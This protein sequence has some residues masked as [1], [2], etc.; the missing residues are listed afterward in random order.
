MIIWI[1]TNLGKHHKVL[2]GTLLGI[3]IVSFV[4]FGTWSRAGKGAG[5]STYLGVDFS[6]SRDCA[7][8]RDLALL[9][10][11]GREGR[12]SADALRMLVF[13]VHLANVVQ[14]PAPT[15]EQL[16]TY[17]DSKQSLDTSGGNFRIVST[18]ERVPALL[19]LLQE[20]A[21]GSREEATRR[22]ENALAESW[23]ISRVNEL[24][25]GPGFAVPY[26]AALLWRGQNT[27]WTLE[28]ASFDG[29]QFNPAIEVPEEALKIYFEN[30][31]EDFRIPHFVRAS[32]AIFKPTP[33]DAEST[34]VE[35]TDG[36]LRKHLYDNAQTI[37]GLDLSKLDEQIK[38]RR[39]EFAQSWRDLQINERLAG[40]IS[41]LLNEQFPFDEVR[42]SEERVAKFLKDE[43]ATSGT[44]PAFNENNIPEN[45]PL[46]S[47][48]LQHALKL[49]K[50][51]WRSDVYVL[52]KGEG[53]VVFF[54][55]EVQPARI[56][57]LDEVREKV[58][59]AW[60][61]QERE[62]L[63]SERATTLERQLRTA[64]ASGKKFTD[65][66]KELGLTTKHFPAFKPAAA[67]EELLLI[68][69]DIWHELSLTQT[70]HITRYF[71]KGTE[72]TYILVEA[73][74]EPL[75]DLKAP[76]ILSLAEQGA[77]R[78]ANRSLSGA[79]VE[80]ISWSAGK[81]Q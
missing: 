74:K 31:K 38:T 56:P 62:R 42:A 77:R 18:R 61:A 28:T 39:A 36:E 24:L 25:T 17:L 30:Q 54:L 14:I 55:Q 53:A 41:S 22:L 80:L 71:R 45:L 63:L 73:R 67:P 59:A 34:P 3:T 69:P 26:E 27:E 44:L 68:G 21:S 47:A 52:A 1:Q 57:S 37:P 72:V 11:V 49:N 8:Y 23:R 81:Q 66:T 35:P 2:L 40:R 29:A 4:F 79:S 64:L 13:N 32:Y 10:G 15:A 46:P 19:D 76:E 75:I 65:I 48:Y 9:E 16:K 51:T 12:I 20:N 7:P 43:G 50:E 6:S 70:G 5:N 78:A 60:R 58:V 33:K